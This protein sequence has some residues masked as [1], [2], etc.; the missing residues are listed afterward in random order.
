VTLDATDLASGILDT[1]TG[2]VDQIEYSLTGAQTGSQQTVPGA[3]TSFG[4]SME[5]VT[6]VD[7]FATDAAGNNESSKALTVRIDETAP[8]INGLPGA[9]CSLW[10][11]D[12]GMRQVAVVTAADLLS[13]VA[14]FE[15]TAASSE[16]SDPQNPDYV[17]TPDGAGGYIV[18][19]RADRLGTGPG[20]LYTV[21]A[22]ARDLAD[23]VRTMT[24]SCAVPHDE[25]Q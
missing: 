20:R 21:T 16:P 5:G 13:G 22:T 7:Y 4:I 14:S 18:S 24:V 17:V 23:N 9:G 25:R 3:S 1:P 8:Q 12:R 6:T 19:L 10:P 11:P 2:W 15:V